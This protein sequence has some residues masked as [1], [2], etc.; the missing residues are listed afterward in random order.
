MHLEQSTTTC[1]GPPLAGTARNRLTVDF[2]PVLISIRPR[3]HPIQTGTSHTV[4]MIPRAAGATRP[5]R[6]LLLVALLL[7]VLHA[8]QAFLPPAV[9]TSPSSHASSSRIEGTRLGSTSGG[10]QGPKRLTISEQLKLSPNRWKRDGKPL[11]PGVGGIWPG[12]P[13]AKTYKVRVRCV[14]VCRVASRGD[15]MGKGRLVLVRPP[16]RSR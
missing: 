4:A 13:D 5:S 3:P 7:A 2:T 8:S 15:W 10:S 9:S 14:G 11:E 1:P 16:I 6:L 12:K